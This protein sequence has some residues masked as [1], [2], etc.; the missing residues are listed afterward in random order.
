M[1]FHMH[2]CT[3]GAVGQTLNTRYSERKENF[4][5]LH[6]WEIPGMAISYGDLT[7]KNYEILYL[8]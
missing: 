8:I 7:K 2:E 5:K 4:V 6:H 3:L 1:Y